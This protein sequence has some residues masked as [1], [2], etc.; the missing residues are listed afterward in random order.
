MIEQSPSSFRIQIVFFFTLL[1]FHPNFASAIIIIIIVIVI[2]IVI[3]IVIISITTIMTITKSSSVSC[4]R[5][6]FTMSPRFGTT[7]YH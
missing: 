3:V 4:K 7:R 1:H 2:M 5:F 6:E